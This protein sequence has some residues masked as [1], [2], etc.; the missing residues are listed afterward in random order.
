MNI[1]EDEETE[2]LKRVERVWKVDHFH[3]WTWSGMFEGVEKAERWISEKAK[4]CRVRG[5]KELKKV[6]KDWK[7]GKY[8][9]ERA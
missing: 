1:W 6:K 2:M 5:L 4:N 9:P 7:A 3:S 8:E